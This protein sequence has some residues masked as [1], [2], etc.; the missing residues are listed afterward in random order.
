MRRIVR[1]VLILLVA[2]SAMSA[3]AQE[4][5][6]ESWMGVYFG[7]VKIGYAS[8]K[9]DR[10]TFESRDLYRLQSTMFNHMTVMGV[11]VEQNVDT[12][13]FLDDKYE[14]VYQT[15]VMSSGGSS[16]SVT[17][18]FEKTKIV[19]E[20]ESQG[21]KIV[22]DIPIPAGTKIMGDSTFVMDVSKLTVGDKISAKTFN[23][24]SLTLDDM[25]M[26]LLRKEDLALGGESIPSFVIK[27]STTM[28]DVT[29]WQD[30]KGNLL[31]AIGLMGI[32]MVREPKE[33]AQIISSNSAGY[34]PPSDLAVLSSATTSTKI[35][36][37]RRVSH[38]KIELSG[39]T[40]RSLVIND[41]RQRVHVSEGDGKLT[42]EYII[43]AAEFDP[44][45]G[46]DLPI[47]DPAL[48]EYLADG[49]YVQPSNSEI[50]EA[51]KAAVG[52][53]KNAYIAAA[54]LRDWVHRNMQ[55]KGEKGIVRPSVDVL[56]TKTGVCR[57]YAVLYTS[58]ARST[59]IPTKLVAGLVYWKGGLYYHAWAE[60]YVGKW[61]P[62]DPTLPMNFVDA[63][64]IKLV[65]GD[66]TSMF[67]MLKTVGSI[68]AKI[69]NFKER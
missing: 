2:Q 45:K 11:T 48:K 28:G 38:L 44:S 34:T 55:P 16:T 5:P 65:E 1:A 43:D 22:K 6:S 54:K 12:T 67:N 30:S 33:T 29:V 35:P 58:L 17:A 60:S 3:M 26:E 68:G 42:A 51:A 56:H 4:I 37:P 46:V 39:L 13:V 27:T 8:F 59:G 49:P 21:S 32:T 62:M 50:S 31:K 25:K 53:T 9:I 10:S 19:A 57:D 66:A 69:I 47:A 52:D 14:P 15:F 20:M 18:R 7:Q 61:V 24:L 41:E 40:D 36:E 63:T 23:P 64:H